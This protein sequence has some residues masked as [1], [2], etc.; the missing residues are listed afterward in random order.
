MLGRLELGDPDWGYVADATSRERRP[1]YQLIDMK[2]GMAELMGNGVASITITHKRLVPDPPRNLH[3]D[4]CAVVNGQSRI[5][6]EFGIGYDFEPKR[7]FPA[8]SPNL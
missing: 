1:L 4:A 7:L 2:N 8:N 3:D 5:V 6:G